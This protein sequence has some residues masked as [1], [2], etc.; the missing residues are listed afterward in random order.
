MSRADRL[1]DGSDGPIVG[2]L[3]RIAKLLAVLVAEGKTQ[4]DAI[5]RLSD[6]GFAPREIAEL[7]GTSSNTVRVT[8]ST[9]R[10]GG[11]LGRRRPA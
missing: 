9:K 2:R 4:T 5:M 8:L 1:G 11:R 10:A 6:V 7:L 3:D